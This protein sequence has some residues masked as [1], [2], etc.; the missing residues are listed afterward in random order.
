[1]GHSKR[2]VDSAALDRIAARA[3]RQISVCTGRT[4]TIGNETCA[5]LWGQILDA[6][7]EL[8]PTVNRKKEPGRHGTQT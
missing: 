2:I 7:R 1:M 4:G 6:I 3:R 8:E 5:A